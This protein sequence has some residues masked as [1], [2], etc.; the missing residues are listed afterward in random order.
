MP[1]GILKQIVIF[2]I[3]KPTEVMSTTVDL[4]CNLKKIVGFM[5]LKYLC[6][7]DAHLVYRMCPF[8]AVHKQLTYAYS[9]YE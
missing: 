9:K 2:D 6:H 7:S 5:S 3:D 8:S 1:L 4:P